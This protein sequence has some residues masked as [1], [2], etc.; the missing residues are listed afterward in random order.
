MYVCRLS[1][2]PAAAD[3]TSAQN[4]S[5]AAVVSILVSKNAGRYRVQ[6]DS[7]PALYVVLAGFVPLDEYVC[8]YVWLIIYYCLELERRLVDKVGAILSNQD[9]SASLTSVVKYVKPT[10]IHTFVFTDVHN[11]DVLNVRS[12]APIL[13]PWMSTMLPS[14]LISKLDNPSARW[15]SNSTTSRIRY[16]IHTLNDRWYLI[17]V[18]MVSFGW[19]KSAFW[20]DSRTKILPR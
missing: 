19:C 18:C 5:G 2:N 11:Y 10:I 12:D 8:M 7:Y 3:T 1:F 6:A 13:C 9:P 16:Y 14:S 17:Y 20:F 4:N 15:T